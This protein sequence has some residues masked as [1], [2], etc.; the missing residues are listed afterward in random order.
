MGKFISVSVALCCLTLAF[1]A[2]TSSSQM[3]QRDVREAVGELRRAVGDAA[4]FLSRVRQDEINDSG[5]FFEGQRQRVRGLAA[6]ARCVEV[7]NDATPPSR[8]KALVA[9]ALRSLVVELSEIATSLTSI[10][11]AHKRAAEMLGSKS[12]EAFD[13]AQGRPRIGV[14]ESI[15]P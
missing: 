13:R 12:F 7:V 3:G 5:I 10:Q 11:E 15:V 4:I 6:L 1:A 14:D 9:A 2:P 8:D